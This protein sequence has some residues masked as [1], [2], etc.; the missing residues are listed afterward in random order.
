VH[1]L[2]ICR[3]LGIERTKPADVMEIVLDNLVS[4][5]ATKFF[6]LDLTGLQLTATDVGW[7][8]GSGSLVGGPA[9]DVVLALGGRPA[10]LAGLGGE[11]ARLL[12]NQLRSP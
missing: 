12:E 10:G 1:S 8:F 5:R 2:D 7:S 6:G 11:G 3:P 9:D 4:S